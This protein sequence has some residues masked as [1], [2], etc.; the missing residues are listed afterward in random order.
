[1]SD[2]QDKSQQTEDASDKRLEDARK[3]GQVATSKEPSTAISFLI[4]ASLSVTGLGSWL[5]SRSE[6]LLTFYLSHEAKI[7]MTPEGMQ[8]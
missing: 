7:D 8:A 2:D 6:H 1:M 3:K 4:M 5:A